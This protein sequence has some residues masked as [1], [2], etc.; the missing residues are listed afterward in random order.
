MSK[1][2]DLIGVLAISSGPSGVLMIPV[3]GASEGSE[4]MFVL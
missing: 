1:S 3:F 2:E 4:L